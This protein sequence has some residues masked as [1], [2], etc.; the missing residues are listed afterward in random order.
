MT[1]RLDVLGCSGSGP[2]PGVPA[3]GYLVRSEKAAIWMD[4]GTGT[5]MELA[6]RLDP[7]ELTAIT[8]SH[9]HA[10]HS[11]DFLGFFHYVAYR[12][13]PPR[14][15]PVFLPPGG[16]ARFA[17]YLDAGAGHAFWEVF[18][19][20]EIVDPVV[21]AV[22]DVEIRFGL[23]RHSVP[24]IVVRVDSGGSSL[25]F[26]G[27]TGPGGALPEFAGDA[28]VLLCEAG[29]N[30]SDADEGPQHHLSGAD[31]G[32]IAAEAG[33]RRL[34]LTHLAPT[35]LADDIRAAAAAEYPGPIVLAKPGLQVAV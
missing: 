17:D 4:A 3:S 8:I 21:H 29:R 12:N 22:A 28:D 34:I 1:L 5:F 16:I 14:P 15:I 31:A 35:L 9:L 13:R 32:R 19:L 23:G 24:S 30:E 20:A 27:D 10:D 33:V 2:A 7:A 25:V 18:D 11:V 6:K 26:S